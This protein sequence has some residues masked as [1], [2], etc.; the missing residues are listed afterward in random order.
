MSIQLL[1]AILSTVSAAPASAPV[2]PP[3]VTSPIAPSPPMIRRSGPRITQTILVQFRQD[4]RMLWS[5]EMMRASDGVASYSQ[6]L[7]ESRACPDTDAAISRFNSA[8]IRNTSL[9]VSV[10]PSFDM[11]DDAVRVSIERT[12]PY[13][14]E[15]GT[16]TD[17]GGTSTVRFEARVAL[18]QGKPVTVAGEGGIAVILTRR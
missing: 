1:A 9:T 18:P 7:R 8:N 4:G 6:Q 16:C 17:N 5:G 13:G 15:T 11:S 2:A 14:A 3:I 12:R 10:G